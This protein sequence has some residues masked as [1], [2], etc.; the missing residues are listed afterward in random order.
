[1]HVVV[2]PTTSPEAVVAWLP[3]HSGPSADADSASV[4]GTDAVLAAM[5]LFSAR[6]AAWASG[7]AFVVATS[8]FAPQVKQEVDDDGLYMQA[9]ILEVGFCIAYVRLPPGTW[10]AG[11]LCLWRRFYHRTC[12]FFLLGCAVLVRCDGVCS[13]LQRWNHCTPS[14]RHCHL[15]LWTM[16][17]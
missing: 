9:G 3:V 12:F 8:P 11:W 4:V 17:R 13:S 6:R 16:R 10:S 15:L 2:C 7:L 1:M 14:T 5:L